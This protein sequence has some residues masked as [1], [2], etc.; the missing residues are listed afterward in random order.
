MVLAPLVSMPTAGR[1]VRARD[2]PSAP[3]IGKERVQTYLDDQRF[4]AGE[5]FF[6]PGDIDGEP[7][8]FAAEQ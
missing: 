4:A 1:S 5:S 2:A 6:N 3:A 8:T 7:G